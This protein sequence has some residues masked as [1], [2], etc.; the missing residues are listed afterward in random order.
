MGR[1]KRK[2]QHRAFVPDVKL[3]MKSRSSGQE[4]YRQENFVNPVNKLQHE[5]IRRTLVQWGT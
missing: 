4:A 1:Q 3:S 5:I 2:N